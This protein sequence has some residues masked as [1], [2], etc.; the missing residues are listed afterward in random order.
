MVNGWE[1][2][3]SVLTPKDK[4]EKYNKYSDKKKSDECSCYGTHP[5]KGQKWVLHC[6]K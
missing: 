6:G 3:V 1:K 2:N 4:T 5:P